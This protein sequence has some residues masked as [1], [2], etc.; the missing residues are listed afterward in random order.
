[1]L[2]GNK[3]F[4]ALLAEYRTGEEGKKALFIIYIY[5]IHSINDAL[6]DFGYKIVANI[7]FFGF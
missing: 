4:S 1:M 3:T 5:F 2:R 6:Q 7:I